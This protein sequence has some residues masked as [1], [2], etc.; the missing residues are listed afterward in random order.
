[1][2]L[3]KWE[4]VFPQIFPL[5]TKKLQQISRRKKKKKKLLNTGRPTAVDVV[6]VTR[7]SLDYSVNAAATPLP[8]ISKIYK[9]IN[10][11]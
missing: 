11:N 3:G 8:H 5:Y 4:W 7:K 6:S 9:K 2:K 1:M 10:K